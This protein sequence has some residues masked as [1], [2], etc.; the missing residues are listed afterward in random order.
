MARQIALL[1]LHGMG[2]TVDNYYETLRN[3]LFAKLDNTTDKLSFQAVNYQRL[4]QPNEQEVWNRMDKGD[5]RWDD[6]RRFL[7]FGFADAAGLETNKEMDGSVYEGAQ[8]DIARKLWAARREMGGD[9]PVVVI[10][11]SLGCQVFSCYVYDAQRE[12]A[13]EKRYAGIWKDIDRFSEQITGSRQPL[14][15]QEK[16]FLRGSTLVGLLTTGCNIPIF[17]AAHKRLSIRAIDRP[18]NQFKWLNL[19]DRHDALGW[20][21]RPPEGG[22]ESLVEDRQVNVGEGLLDWLKSFTPMSHTAYWEDDDVIAALA[23]MI[24]QG[25]LHPITTSPVLPPSGAPAPDPR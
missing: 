15:P 18:N 10:A 7:L 3:K 22:Y 4:L 23:R 8:L 1:T 25:L 12:A 5:L 6:L 9:G 21:L 13:G 17:V 11:Q 24:M 19:F 14:S 20:P 2:E 16:S